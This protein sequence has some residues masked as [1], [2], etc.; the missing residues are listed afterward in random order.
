MITGNTRQHVQVGV[1]NAAAKARTVALDLNAGAARWRAVAQLRSRV[2]D[3]ES[4]QLESFHIRI[5]IR[6]DSVH[7]DAAATPALDARR[8][9]SSGRVDETTHRDDVC[10]PERGKLR[11]LDAGVVECGGAVRANGLT[12]HDE[13]TGRKIDGH[14]RSGDVV[15]EAH[16]HCVARGPAAVNRSLDTHDLADAQL[17]LCTRL[18]VDG[19]L[20]AAGTVFDTID[21]DAAESRD[22]A[23]GNAAAVDTGDFRIA[24]AA[25]HDQSR[26]QDGQNSREQSCRSLGAH[27]LA[28]R[29]MSSSIT[30]DYNRKQ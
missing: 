14:D 7:L 10:R 9:D 20:R 13:G 24:I 2:V 17:R 18:P 12:E 21:K 5:E 11:R 16:R 4:V 27:L 1:E 30:T 29:S 25:T 28:P 22:C 3:D 23:K 15:V 19:D 26:A 6:D 8:D